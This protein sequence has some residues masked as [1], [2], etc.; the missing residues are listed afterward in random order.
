MKF[1]RN[2]IPTNLTDFGSM[3]FLFAAVPITF[4]F[5]ITIV[6]PQLYVA[7]TFLYYFHIVAATFIFCNVLSNTVC[8]IV[9]DTSIRGEMLNVPDT[10]SP[11][12]TKL[13]RLCA[14][15]ETLVPPRSWH[16]NVCNICV[17]KRD[18]HC[19]FTGC[20]V[21]HTNQRYFLMLLLYVFVGSLYASL[22][23]NYF[24]WWL[25]ADVFW[26]SSTILK[27]VFPLLMFA[28]DA[29]TGQYY[30]IVYLINMIG[31]MFSGFLLFYHMRNVLSGAVSYEQCVTPYN[32]GRRRNIEMV[33]GRKW[34]LTWISPFYKSELPHDGIHW[35]TVLEASSKRR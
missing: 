12:E 7:G 11:M 8:V 21:G 32:L 14:V 31:A 26:N 23:N 5:E 24:I 30:L 33:F 13:W 9:C 27:L 15:C 20:C 3:L 22:Y 10:L 6:L 25:N 17:L 35:E 16:C 2:I 34:Y 4:V 1:R 19:A 29:N 18:H 28:W